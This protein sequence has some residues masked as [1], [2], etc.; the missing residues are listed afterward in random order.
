MGTHRW[1]GKTQTNLFGSKSDEISSVFVSE[2]YQEMYY[3]PDYWL[4]TRNVN[5]R[6]IRYAKNEINILLNISTPIPY[7]DSYEFRYYLFVLKIAFLR[8]RHFSLLL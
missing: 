8:S 7:S 2:K 4:L 6:Y 5:R 3:N 1:N